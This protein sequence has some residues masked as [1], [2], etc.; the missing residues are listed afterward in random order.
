MECHYYDD[1][2]KRPRHQPSAAAR[3]PMKDFAERFKK[4]RLARNLSQ[5]ELAQLLDIDVMQVNRYERGISVPSAT[6]LPAIAKLFQMTVGQLL[7]L[8]E[9][10]TEPPA[11]RDLRLFERFRVLDRM[12]RADREIVLQLIDAMI[13]KRKMA[14]VLQG[15]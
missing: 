13:A 4:A 12:P 3:G 10:S 9:E 14:E 15:A 1:M 11:I 6:T 5:H 7:G 2:E 8:E